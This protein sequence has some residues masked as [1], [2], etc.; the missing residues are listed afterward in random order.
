MAESFTANDG[1]QMRR[2]LTLAARGT[3]RVEPNPM[4]GCVIARGTR[5]VGEGHHR[6]FGGPHAEVNALRAAGPQAR[7]ATAYVTLEPCC[8][9]GKTPPCTDALIAA[10]V[11]R[12]VIAMRDPFPKARGR[13]LRL[14]RSAGIDVAA[15]LC[16]AEAVALNAP[17][18]KRQRT[19]RPW[20]I[21]KW[22]QSL[23]GK[24]ATRSGDSQW[25]SGDRSRLKA[26]QLRGRVDAII[27][28]VG[29][30][31]ADDP[32][33]TCRHG[34]PRRIASRI[35]ID[36]RLRTAKRAQLVRTAGEVPTIIATDRRTAKTARAAGFERAGI[37]MLCLRHTR[38]GLDLGQLLD[39]LGR[40]GMTNVLV[41]GGGKTLGSFFDAGLADEAIIF[42][43]RRLI[44]GQLAPSP[45]G[46][47]G[48]RLMSDVRAPARTQVARCGQDDLYR[49]L[50]NDLASRSGRFW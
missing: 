24:I 16:E 45:L 6:R 8:H 14:L 23:D 35:V 7:G 22:A 13:G 30:V 33:L 44:G 20:V 46:G 32:L 3:G 4:V 34:K 25:I 28:G 27:V 10:R 42:V 15:R 5:V 11:R 1:R 2:A 36:P 9:H 31:L 37:E 41:E 47:L 39:E 50:L 43:S 48:P 18:L 12:V 29:T 17:Y 26:H 40:R 38:D 21:L 19:G 49:L